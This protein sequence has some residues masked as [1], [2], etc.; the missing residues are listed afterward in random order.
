MMRKLKKTT[1]ALFGMMFVLP[2][3]SIGSGTVIQSE[4]TQS[5][6]LIEYDEEA[7]LLVI[8]GG[9]VFFVKCSA[10]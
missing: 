7:T 3:L 6:K 4:M 9:K 2:C 1:I 5:M 10:I 8:E